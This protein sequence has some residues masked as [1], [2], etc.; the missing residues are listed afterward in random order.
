MTQ[1]TAASSYPRTLGLVSGLLALALSTVH[2]AAG[3]NPPPRIQEVL[4]DGSGSDAEEAFT[5]IAGEAGTALDGWSLVGVKRQ[6]RGGLSHHRPRRGDHS[7][8]RPAG[9]GPRKCHRGGPDSPGL[10]RQRRLAERPRRGSAARSPGPGRRRP[11]VRRCRRAQRRR[12]DSG[13]SGGGGPESLPGR[14]RVGHRRQSGRLT[15]Q[16]TPTPGT[17]ASPPGPGQPSTPGSGTPSGPRLVLPDTDGL[18]RNAH[19][20]SGAADRGHRR[21]HRRGRAF[22]GL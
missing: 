1:R 8:G 5:E 22:R 16:D 12:G 6:Q 7:G 15:A 14:G 3:Q 11:S 13:A 18:L 2:P 20:P 21:G 17:G 4:Y 19:R 9:R 10:H